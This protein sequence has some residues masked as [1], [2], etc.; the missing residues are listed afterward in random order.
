MTHTKTEETTPDQLMEPFQGRSLRSILI[1]TLVVH[2]VV[3][4][5]ASVPYLLKTVTGGDSDKLSEKERVDIAVKEATASIKEI[6]E[7][8]GLKPQD[9]GDRFAGGSPKAEAP[10]PD[11]KAEPSNPQ[12]TDPA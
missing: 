4:V 2:A 1:F 12:T 5:V 8:H 6:A 10:T 7:K 3:L 9:L 11:A